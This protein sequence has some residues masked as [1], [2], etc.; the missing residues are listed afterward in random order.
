M[1]LNEINKDTYLSYRPSLWGW[2]AWRHQ[3]DDIDW[4]VKD[5]EN[6]IKNKKEI[7]K[8]N[9][10]GIDMSRMLIHCMEGK[11]IT[12]M[13]CINKK[14]SVCIQD[15]QKFKILAL[16]MAQQTVQV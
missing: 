11:K 15:Y 13:Q 1:S 4:N 7:K 5:F 10:G 8:F 2:A 12:L 16:E 14:G 6:F 3:W 9:R